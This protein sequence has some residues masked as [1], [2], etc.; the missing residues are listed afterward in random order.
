MSAS[1]K[2]TEEWRLGVEPGAHETPEVPEE[3]GAP[4][5]YSAERL[6]R[7][8]C[9]VTAEH[10]GW[11]KIGALAVLS[12]LVMLGARPLDSVEARHALSELALLQNGA[13]AAAHLSWV[14]LLEA[15]IFVALGAGDFCAR[16]MFALSG[17]LLIAAAF[18]M[19]RHLG[20][21]GAMAFAALLMLS[22]SVAYYS[23]ADSIVPTLA[24]AVLALA[25]FLQL[26]AEPGR[27]LAA[28]LGA[29]V[30]LGLA[31][32][33][34]ALMTALFMFGGLA[35][36]GLFAALRG[37]RIRLQVRVWWTRRKGLFLITIFVA[38]LIWM[39]CESGFFTRSPLA[40]IVAAFRSNLPSVGPAA[41]QSFAAGLDFYLPILLLYEFLI[42]L[43]GVGGALAV[44]TLRI[45]SRIATGA[46]IWSA[47]AVAFYL[48]TPVRSPAL[49][50]QMVV[51]VALLGAVLIDSLHH[52]AAW[53][54]V[55]YPLAVLAVLT[56]C[57]QAANNFMW[58]AP[59]ASQAPWAR[60][61]LLYWTEPTTT[62]QTPVQCA[63]VTSQAPPR[64]ASMFFAAESPV[65]RWYLRTFTPV[66]KPQGATAIVSNADSA[67]LSEA[68]GLTAYEFE[69]DDAW[70]PAWRSLSPQTV[71]HYMVSAHAWAPLDAHRMAIAIRP[72]VTV[73][74]TVILAPVEPASSPT[75]SAL[76]AQAPTPAAAASPTSEI[77]AVPSASARPALG[78]GP[79]SSPSTTPS[80]TPA[81]T[82]SATPAAASAATQITTPAATVPATP[83]ATPAVTAVPTPWAIPSSVPTRGP[84][85]AAT[86]APAGRMGRARRR[87]VD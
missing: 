47:L 38:A 25:L 28:A 21:A 37:S 48:W 58:Y 80:G 5:D 59:D 86:S 16:L 4:R 36:V 62:F 23:R 34:A 12:R 60:T 63:R 49:V 11:A 33:D 8:L 56:L 44:L 72:V 64:G 7:P 75:A 3:Q 14:H 43:L 39:G 66:A 22:P 10:L 57:V 83:M 61:A 76:P 50:L 51:P 19:R 68:E 85:A 87:L 9:V 30:G 81:A 73:A 79:E 82:L 17:L 1:G 67:S 29:A 45:R 26:T 27:L 54:L 13:P 32:A 41:G 24:F 18:A 15:A 53:S 40:A 6:D 52:T 74:P 69:L 78:A 71:L 31:S 2:E 46:L 77:S 35:V 20:R 42:V 65:L 55:R 84:A 70:H